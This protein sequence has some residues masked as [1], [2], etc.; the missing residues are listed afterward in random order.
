MVCGLK[1]PLF[2]FLKTMALFLTPFG[3]VTSSVCVG[4][5]LFCFITKAISSH[6]IKSTVHILARLVQDLCVWT[7]SL[8]NIWVVKFVQ[9]QMENVGCLTVSELLLYW[10][11]SLHSQGE[12]SVGGY[13][14][15][16]KWPTGIAGHMLYRCSC[17]SESITSPSIWSYCSSEEAAKCVLFISLT[18]AW[19][20]FG[21]SLKFLMF[22]GSTP[23]CCFTQRKHK[24]ALCF[25]ANK[26]WSIVAE[27]L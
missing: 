23:Q 25:P 20:F 24:T 9:Q 19:L 5:L 12:E 17:S 7:G 16:N 26:K 21:Q 11:L 13:P 22:V 18:W 1:L 27:I 3:V 4:G 14:F 2:N 10:F 8:K 15:P 6:L